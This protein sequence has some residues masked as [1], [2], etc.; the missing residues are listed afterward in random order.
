MGLPTVTADLVS[1]VGPDVLK[2]LVETQTDLDENK[3][4]GIG[5]LNWADVL[6]ADQLKTESYGW[7]RPLLPSYLSDIID[8]FLN[9]NTESSSTGTLAIGPGTFAAEHCAIAACAAWPDNRQH[10]FFQDQYG[11]IRQIKYDF[12]KGKYT[13]GGDSN[14]LV[15][16]DNAKPGTPLAAIGYEVESEK[17]DM[18]RLFYLNDKNFVRCIVHNG[19][20]WKTDTEFNKCLIQVDPDSKIAVAY[21]HQENSVHLYYQTSD[22][23]VNEH[24]STSEAGWVHQGVVSTG[25]GSAAPAI[26]GSPIAAAVSPDGNELDVFYQDSSSN[27]RRFVKKSN[28]NWVEI[29]HISEPYPKCS[30]AAALHRDASLLRVITFNGLIMEFPWTKEGDLE[31]SKELVADAIP[32]SN[33]ALVSFVES[34]IIITKT[35]YQG[36][37]NELLS[38]ET[39]NGASAGLPLMWV[40]E[41]GLDE[42]SWIFLVFT[43]FTFLI[44]IFLMAS[45]WMEISFIL[46][47]WLTYSSIMRMFGVFT[48]KP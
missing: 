29:G 3:K 25:S 31:P 28:E 33:I 43:G 17:R 22:G 48:L 13:G 14:R 24:V 18:I 46:S 40:T 2:R 12:D 7:L 47:L 45:I 20:W 16:A 1:Q 15:L 21:N 30:F 11:G 32:S 23:Q 4:A 38:L 44:N 26:I 39:N 19:Q 36:D 6:K 5:N 41:A 37:L 8:A 35:F 27:I 42:S 9:P 34:E 10:I